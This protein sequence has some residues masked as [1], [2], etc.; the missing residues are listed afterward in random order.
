MKHTFQP[1]NANMQHV[2]FVAIEQVGYKRLIET[3]PNQ[4]RKQNAEN[5]CKGIAMKYFGSNYR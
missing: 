4:D 5:K 2:A 1:F 3:A